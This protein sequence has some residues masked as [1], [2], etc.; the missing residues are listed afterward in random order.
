MV[1]TLDHLRS[2]D[3]FLRAGPEW[4]RERMERRQRDM[5]L[6]C[7]AAVVVGAGVYGAVMGSWRNETQALYTGIK[8][9]L[10]ILLTTLGNGLLN[11]MLAPLLGLNITFRQSLNMVLM[12]FAI[13]AIVLGALSP[14]ALFVI[15]N[16]PPLTTG[17]RLSSMEYGFLQ[18]TLTVFVALAGIVGNVRLFPL[19]RHWAGRPSTALKVLLAWLAGNLFLGSQIAWMLRPFIWDANRPVEFIGPDFLQGSFFETIFNILCRLILS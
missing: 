6:V 9:P 17:T 15:W 1:A 8:L 14:V 7:V 3:A 18:L 12:S 2:F 19:L 16:T 4:L 13:A 11:G 5:M 10:V